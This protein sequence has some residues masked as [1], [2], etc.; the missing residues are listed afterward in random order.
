MRQ[1]VF[2]RSVVVFILS[3]PSC[4]LL[5]RPAIAEADACTGWRAMRNIHPGDNSQLEGVDAV[6]ASDAWAVGAGEEAAGNRALV[7]HWNGRRWTAAAVDPIEGGL[8]SVDM[9]SSSDVWAVGDVD[10]GADVET[11][12][13]HW[14]GHSW[15][16]VPTPSPGSVENLLFSVSGIS[17]S[18]TWAVGRAAGS[19]GVVEGLA[20]HWDGQSWQ[21]VAT[22]NPSTYTILNAVAARSSDDAWA[23]GRT[24]QDSLIEHWDGHQWSVVASPLQAELR[25]VV[26]LSGS[27]AWA[28]GNTTGSEERSLIVHWDGYSWSVAA[29]H[30]FSHYYDSLNGLAGAPDGYLWAVGTSGMSEIGSEAETIVLRW[31]GLR[32]SRVSS[33]N[34][35]G[36]RDE[37][38]AVAVGGG[39]GFAVGGSWPGPYPGDPLIEGSC[40]GA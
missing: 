18:D 4:L 13:E 20:E 3:A 31:N 8:L 17:P 9:I 23:V 27:N 35:S 29:I 40:T 26:A 1:S 15:H 39:R 2:A 28:V 22:P 38:T 37:L 32:W 21:A 11:L 10:Q 12:A 33:E 14:D 7:E 25:G 24:D 36:Y 5:P 30:A 34:P 6:S 19:G 16:V